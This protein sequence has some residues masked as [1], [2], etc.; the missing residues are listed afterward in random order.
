MATINDTLALNNGIHIPQ[1]GFGCYLIPDG[2]ST[3]QA[4]NS[5]LEVGYR[6][7]DTARLYGNEIS[8][9]EAIR[10]SNVPR[11]E[12][13]V[14]TKLWNSDHGYDEALR[15]F[16]YSFR[17]LDLDYIDLFL[18]HW[19]VPGKRM[20]SW[21]ALENLY[22]QGLV[23]AIGVSNYMLPHLEEIMAKGETAPTI[24]Q[25]ELSPYN[26]LRR[27]T[28]IEFCRKNKIQIQAYCPLT[29]GDKL[30]DPFLIEKAQTYGKTSAQLLIK[31]SL[32][33]GFIPL[34]KSTQPERISENADLY[35]FTISREDM[36]EL[37][38]LNENLAVSWD[39][40]GAP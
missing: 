29:R 33:K 20:A 37:D 1:L 19:P 17:C 28:E 25:I 30:A 10:A 18:I 6:H 38:N 36:T 27:K 8:L 2:E 35:D 34:P 13:F 21:K 5:A 32:Q 23:K 31:W 39:P 26:L 11:E 9:G 22:Q 4:I 7:F 24:N 16:E 14:T 3:H 40:T 12:V 15:A